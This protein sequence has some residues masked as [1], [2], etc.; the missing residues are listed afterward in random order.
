MAIYVML[1]IAFTFSITLEVAIC[2]IK[3]DNF[4]ASGNVEPAP[5]P[6][7]P[8]SLLFDDDSDDERLSLLEQEEELSAVIP[9][10]KLF[11]QENVPRDV[12][13]IRVASRV[14]FTV[15]F[16]WMVFGLLGWAFYHV[17][18]EWGNM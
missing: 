6:P 7:G 12:I 5:P 18:F 4:A 9:G 17:W 15:F 3:C 1:S 10:Q 8:R 11:N 2:K 16:C 14:G 13:R